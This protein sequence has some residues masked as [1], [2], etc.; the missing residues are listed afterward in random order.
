M[1]DAQEVKKI[2]QAFFSLD[3]Q[4]TGMICRDDFKRII[5]KVRPLLSDEDL[6]R[7]FTEVD[8]HKNDKINYTEFLIATINFQKYLTEDNI[9]ALFKQFDADNS[10]R[11]T[12]SDIISAMHKMGEEIEDY[13]LKEMMH[14]YRFNQSEGLDLKMFKKIFL[15]L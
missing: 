1:L 15:E 2:S 6:N 3:K 11:I 14:K 12:P 7:I 9:K 10:G 13:E 5:S 8:R 4:A